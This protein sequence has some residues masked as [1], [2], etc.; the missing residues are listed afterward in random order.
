MNSRI[1]FNRPAITGKECEHIA[2]AAAN[3]H[4]AGDGSFTK[5]CQMVLERVTG[6]K[7]ALLTPSCTHAL[8]MCALLLEIK[9]G[10]EVIIPS[11]TFV[12]T[13][14][15][16]A[17]RGARIVFA[18]SRPDTL[19]L[20]ETKLEALIT[21]RTKVIVPMHYA[22]VGCENRIEERLS[23]LVKNRVYSLVRSRF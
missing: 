2:K 21:P 1:P 5:D 15:A 16:F 11:F 8:E 20:D 6:A 9:A 18:D 12:S 4:L 14:N 10:D 3:G 22:G 19:N 17:L 23:T 7:K 13:A